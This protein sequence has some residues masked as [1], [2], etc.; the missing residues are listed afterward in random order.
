VARDWAAEPTRE[1]AY[2]KERTLARAVY[3]EPRRRCHPLPD[4]TATST[5]R[6]SIPWN[7]VRTAP[8]ARPRAGCRSPSG[9]ISRIRP[10]S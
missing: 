9:H 7:H 8:W 1:S 6:R 10:T 2:D 4:D 5:A 3:A